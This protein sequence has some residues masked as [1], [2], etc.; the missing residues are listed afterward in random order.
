[1]A[2]SS[3]DL[4]RSQAPEPPRWGIPAAVDE[5]GHGGSK[6]ERKMHM[7]NRLWS[8]VVGG[9]MGALLW[10]GPVGAKPESSAV[11]PGDGVDGPA[12]RYTPNGDG[13]AGHFG[14]GHVL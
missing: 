12:L 6:H 7:R 5:Q 14:V 3:M 10:A 9:V 13:T 1:M 8:I 2:L 11:F 4:R